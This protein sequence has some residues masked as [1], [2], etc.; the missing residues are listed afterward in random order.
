L[1][2]LTQ[3]V[4]GVYAVTPLPARTI[5]E[6]PNGSESRARRCYSELLQDESGSDQESAVV[7]SSSNFRKRARIGEPLGDSLQLPPEGQPVG[8]TVPESTR[9]DAACE[10]EYVARVHST[11]NPP[12]RARAL[13]Q[14]YATPV[15]AANYG[16]SDL[17]A[18]NLTQGVLQ[19]ACKR[20]G[21]SSSGAKAVLLGRL[22]HAGRT[23]YAEIKK[24]AEEFE[25]TRER[26]PSAS[27]MGTS[28]DR[29]P[30]WTKHETA[31]LCH[32]ISDPRNS[33]ALRNLYNRAESRAEIDQ[34]R[35][36]PWSNEFPDLFNT[37]SYE[38]DVPLISGG[39]VQTE[40]DQFDPGWH[41][42]ERSGG[43][44]K[45]KWASLRSKFSV[46]Y[47]NWSA[48]GQGDPESFPDFADG[49]VGLV[50]MF[51]VFNGKPALEFAIRLLPEGA[52]AEEGVPGFDSRHQ[53]GPY[54]ENRKGRQA[55][56][57]SYNSS[58]G[59]IASQ[60]AS[61]ISQPLR[62][63]QVEKGY[64]NESHKENTSMA[65]TVL[66][67]MELESKLRKCLEECVD[68]DDRK[69]VLLTRLKNVSDRIAAS[70]GL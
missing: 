40:L 52:R 26:I 67:L 17:P 6:Q 20:V 23:S 44:L 39:A 19:L 28:R 66:R 27:G 43:L 58:I 10:Y 63:E 11:H 41:P 3:A 50:Y 51:C 54:G 4:H 56:R 24:L 18:V 12:A 60:L 15:S 55:G 16:L 1:V 9:G 45:K 70:M 37:K 14:T 25:D 36:D 7:D 30:N 21:V 33:T 64:S 69:E 48:S 22:G 38:P 31:R 35:H 53:R 61:A 46:A 65:D 13:E 42:H 49:D 5:M 32:V 57:A 47:T 59:D 62:I 34:G 29:E 8:A 68:E 2:K